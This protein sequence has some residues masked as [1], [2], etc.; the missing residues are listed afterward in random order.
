VEPSKP[1]SDEASRHAPPPKD[2]EP[3]PLRKVPLSEDEADL[4]IA[5][6]RKDEPGIP[7]EQVLAEHGYSLDD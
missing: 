4:I 7:I 3:V 2:P 1:K 6:R 5:L